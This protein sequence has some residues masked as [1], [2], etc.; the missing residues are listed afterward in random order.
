MVDRMY[1]GHIEHIGPD[2]LTGVG[3]TMPVIVYLRLR[4][5]GEHGRRSQGFHY[6]GKGEK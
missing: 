3:V 4:R 6:D 5:S 1:I 2:A